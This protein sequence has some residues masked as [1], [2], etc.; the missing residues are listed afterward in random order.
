MHQRIQEGHTIDEIAAYL[1]MYGYD[2]R[3]IDY[4]IAQHTG[5]PVEPTTVSGKHVGAQ[6]DEFLEHLA[7][8]NA[9]EFFKRLYLLVR[10][11]SFFFTHLYSAGALMGFRMFCFSMLVSLS[12]GLVFWFTF[13]YTNVFLHLPEWLAPVVSLRLTAKTFVLFF[14]I[15]IVFH[16]LYYFVIH[17]NRAN[18]TYKQFLTGMFFSLTPFIMFSSVP[19]LNVLSIFFSL[20]LAEIAFRFYF[21]ADARTIF[22]IGA[23]YTIGLA[24]VALGLTIL[25]I[26]GI[27][28]PDQQCVVYPQ[29]ECA[30]ARTGWNS[31]SIRG[32]EESYIE[33][34]SRSD[35]LVCSGTNTTAIVCERILAPGGYYFTTSS[36]AGAFTLI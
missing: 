10:Y 21:D 13:F 15:L 1:R 26:P 33:V 32:V 11:P 27:S 8:V 30:V 36:S 5:Q 25:F 7:P 16:P 20:H 18:L 17:R 34:R 6:N 3:H 2:K 29:G 14:F 35:A 28:T 4:L 31:L 23:I 24:V 12:L 22:D 19:V 9:K